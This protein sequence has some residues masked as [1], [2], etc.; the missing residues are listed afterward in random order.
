LPRYLGTYGWPSNSPV[1]GSLRQ[2]LLAQSS[3][4]RVLPM[5]TSVAG[6]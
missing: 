2:I 5:L 3:T 6:N 1:A 4:G